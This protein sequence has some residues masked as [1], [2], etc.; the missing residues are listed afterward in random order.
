MSEEIEDVIGPSEHEIKE[1]ARLDH[2]SLAKGEARELMAVIAS[3]IRFD[4]LLATVED[5]ADSPALGQ[6]DSGYVPS[7]AENPFNSFIRRCR[8]RTSDTGPL[9]GLTVGL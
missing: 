7:A 4:E 1:L 2:I 9:A 3:L 5:R 6:R 8:V